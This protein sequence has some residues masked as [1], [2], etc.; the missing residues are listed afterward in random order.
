MGVI[1]TFLSTAVLGGTGSLAGFAF[2]TR[3]A[4]FVPLSPTDAIFNSPAYL[5]NN[6]NKNPASQD[7]CVRRVPLSKIKPHLLEKEAEGK[8][9]EAFCQGLWSGL[10]EENEKRMERKNK[11]QDIHRWLIPNAHKT[12]Y[13]YQRHYLEKKYRNTTTTAHQLW[14]RQELATST[15]EPGTQITDHFE[16]VSKTP[17]S[18]VVR[19]GGSPLE[20]GVRASDGLFEMGVQIKKDEGVAEFRLKSVFYTGLGKAEA[21]PMPLHVLFAH[22]LYTKLWMETAVGN[23]MM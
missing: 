15:Y 1:R 3:H 17:E 20:Q 12:G 11:R 8:L 9:T 6:P 4:K 16:V 14:E 13:A 2:W 10:E 19:C 5:R 7:L 18:I 21:G 23:V 22:K